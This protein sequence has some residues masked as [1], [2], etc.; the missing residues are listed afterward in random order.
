MAGL[1]VFLK[2]RL[3]GGIWAASMDREELGVGHST[4]WMLQ[5]GLDCEKLESD[6]VG[7]FLGRDE[8]PFS[9]ARV[10]SQEGFCDPV[11]LLDSI[12]DKAVEKGL[13]LMLGHPV[14]TVSSGLETLSVEGDGFRMDA[15]LVVFS[16][17]GAVAEVD[18]WF[19]QKIFP[20]RAQHLWSAELG[21][22][23]RT[24]RSQHGYVHWGPARQGG[25]VSGCR[26]A[27]PHLEV[28]ES[29]HGLHA[30]VSGRLLGLRKN[31]AWKTM[32][33]SWN[34]VRSWVFHAMLF[35]L[36]DRFQA[37]RESW[38]VGG[39]MARTWASLWPVPTGSPRAF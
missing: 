6:A 8:H 34:G 16:A 22:F 33:Q 11:E 9:V 36:S 12:A 14:K 21:G 15:E 39:T 3:C 18:S 26:W 19:R 38:L 4:E 28:G 31:W 10:H 20:V 35:R 1:E 7:A 25:V 37:S 17:G 29:R 23:K 13:V 24:G 5:Q 30:G 27:S 32:L 2:D